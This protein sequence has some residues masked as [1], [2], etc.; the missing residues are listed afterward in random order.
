LASAPPLEALKNVQRPTS[1]SH[2][3]AN[4]DAK[5]SHISG[6]IPEHAN[7]KVNGNTQDS[8]QVVGPKLSISTEHSAE[9]IHVENCPPSNMDPDLR[10][11]SLENRF[12]PPRTDPIPE[13]EEETSSVNNNNG[14]FTITQKDDDQI[15]QYNY[16]NDP[17]YIRDINNPFL[18]SASFRARKGL[19]E[20]LT[21]K[22]NGASSLAPPPSWS[23][24]KKDK[25]QTVKK[26]KEQNGLKKTED[27]NLQGVIGK[28]ISTLIVVS[29]SNA[30]I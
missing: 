2:Q 15:Q 19:L 8:L 3:V 23:L 18:V 17:N 26:R 21:R 11:D 14:I 5:I 9:S 20:P 16:K 6:N 29:T 22:S 13:N 28:I 30:S 1:P 25:P 12:S 4:G 27:Y 24:I 10:R 7:I